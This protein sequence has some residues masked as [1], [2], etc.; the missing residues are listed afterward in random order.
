MKSLI[1]NQRLSKN[2]KNRLTW[3]TLQFKSLKILFSIIT[4]K[5]NFTMVF[6][7]KAKKSQNRAS[8][9]IFEAQILAVHQTCVMLIDAKHSL[10]WQCVVNIA[11]IRESVQFLDLVIACKSI[12][13]TP[14]VLSIAHQICVCGF[15]PTSARH[16]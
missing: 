12:Y 3:S 14:G 2:I 7:T 16:T 5:E 4:L 8:T 15:V 11:M 13:C 10:M 1:N 9:W 6:L